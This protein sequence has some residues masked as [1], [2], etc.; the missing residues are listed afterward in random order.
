MR[1][2]CKIHIFTQQTYPKTFIFFILFFRKFLIKYIDPNI[3]LMK[4][5]HSKFIIFLS[6]RYDAINHLAP[7]HLKTCF[8]LWFFVILCDSLVCSLCSFCSRYL[9]HVKCPILAE[10]FE[11]HGALQVTGRVMSGKCHA[12]VVYLKFRRFLDQK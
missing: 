6:P 9:N 1:I 4:Y 7:G 12:G 8:S 11:K 3:H 10:K 2:Y 5:I